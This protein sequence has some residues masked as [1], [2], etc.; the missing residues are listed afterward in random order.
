MTSRDREAAVSSNGHAYEDSP[1]TNNPG[2]SYQGFF[3]ALLAYQVLPGV[4]AQAIGGSGGTSDSFTTYVPE[5]TSLALLG[6]G[7]L[8]LARRRR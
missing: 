3:D 7:G 8:L 1:I 5:P 4:H 6:L 2:I